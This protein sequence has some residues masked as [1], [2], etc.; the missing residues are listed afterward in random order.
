MMQRNELKF[1]S[2][3]LTFSST[4]KYNYR[5][6]RHFCT[7]RSVFV[8]FR[9]VVVCFT[10]AILPA[11]ILLPG[12]GGAAAG[13]RGGGAGAAL[14]ALTLHLLGVQ[15]AFYHHLHYFITCKN[16]KEHYS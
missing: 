10:A 1:R 14:P 9:V 16:R 11:H 3:N 5:D 8:V 7:V 4:S 13:P 15:F 2:L 12:R 6:M